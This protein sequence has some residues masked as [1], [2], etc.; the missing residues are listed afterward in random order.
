MGVMSD[1]SARAFGAAPAR[2]F[3]RSAGISGSGS[4][5][6]GAISSVTTSPASAPA[7]SASFR[8][9]L[10]QW[11][12]WP[13]GSRV[14]WNGTPLIVPSIAVMPRE[15]SFALAPFGRT[16]KVQ[17]STLALS[18]GR[19]S[20]ALKR[21]LEAILVIL[22]C[23]N[24]RLETRSLPALTHVLPPISTSRFCP[25]MSLAS[26]RLR[27]LAPTLVTLPSISLIPFARFTP[28]Q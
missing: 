23:Q 18:A 12:F 11:L 7:A 10:S 19:K 16:R 28:R 22:L 8:S 21:I 6:A 3:L 13:S 27:S 5:A 25:S 1:H 2:A 9:T 15:G 26:P 17:E 20:F 14:A 4:S 24:R